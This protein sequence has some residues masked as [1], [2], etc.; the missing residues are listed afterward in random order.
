[1]A[2]VL[3]SGLLLSSLPPITVEA[4]FLKTFSKASTRNFGVPRFSPAGSHWIQTLRN[5][6]VRFSNTESYDSL[7][8]GLDIIGV[9]LSEFE[10]RPDQKEARIEQA[11]HALG[12]ELRPIAD[13]AMTRLAETAQS[14]VLDMEL[15]RQDADYLARAYAPHLLRWALARLA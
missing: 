5:S 3:T 10:S 12:I 4:R 13:L 1:M 2:L 9:D 8:H 14:G 6:G 15:A 11:R 7:V